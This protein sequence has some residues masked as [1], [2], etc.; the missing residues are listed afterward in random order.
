M[1]QYPT[2][3]ACLK[4]A[5]ATGAAA[6]SV[7][8]A[9]GAVFKLLRVELHLSAAPTTSQNYT[10]TLDAGD[11][12]NYDAV[13]VTRDLSVGSV[14]SLV[15]VFGDGYEFEADDEIDI[16]YTNTDVVT[17]GIRIVYEVI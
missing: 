12:D 4:T 16:A 8:L 15:S 11:G 5:V 3:T 14:I 7:A 13:L 2:G 17:Y 6:I 1:A 10:I 9:P